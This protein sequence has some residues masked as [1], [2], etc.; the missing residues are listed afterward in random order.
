V[1]LSGLEPRRS[2]L[3]RGILIARSARPLDAAT[4]RA[5]W[6]ALSTMDSRLGV[7]I[8]FRNSR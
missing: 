2:D 3:A 8:D 5:I 4:Q 1:D 7:G 6:D